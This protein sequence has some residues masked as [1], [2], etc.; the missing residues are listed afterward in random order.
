MDYGLSIRGTPSIIIILEQKGIKKTVNKLWLPLAFGAFFCWG[1]LSLTSK[2]LFNQGVNIYVFLSYLYFVVTILI[3]ADLKIKKVKINRK[4]SFLIFLLI[5]IFS[6]SFNLFMF[7]A[8]KTA[9]NVGYVNAINASSISLVT[10]F[11]ILLFKDEFSLRK[12]IGFLGSIAGLILL[13]T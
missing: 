13:V 10:V 4:K 2:F 6:T 3:L 5:G 1:L 11:S 9:P 7:E 8:I 12:L